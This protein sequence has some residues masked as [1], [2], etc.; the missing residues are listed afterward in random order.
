MTFVNSF[1]AEWLKRRRS[2]PALR[3]RQLQAGA[4]DLAL[5][6]GKTLGRLR[7]DPLEFPG[8]LEQAVDVLVRLERG[9]ERDRARA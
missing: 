6:L 8:A 5:D 2:L 3:R 7:G 9:I 4:P 1:R